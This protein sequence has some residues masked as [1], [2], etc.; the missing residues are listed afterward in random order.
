MYARKCS[1]AVLRRPFDLCVSVC[2]S[3]WLHTH[4]HTHTSYVSATVDVTWPDHCL[5]AS[6]FSDPEIQSNWS[7]HRKKKKNTHKENQDS[8]HT[9]V[10]KRA[11]WTKLQTSY[12]MAYN[13][14]CPLC[15]QMIF[16]RWA[17][18]SALKMLAEFKPADVKKTKTFHS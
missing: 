12:V 17:W 1:G 15:T 2:L 11:R 4:I 9:S 6:S 13:L 5:L 3:A 8:F 7:E 14:V 16:S 18:S 10:Q